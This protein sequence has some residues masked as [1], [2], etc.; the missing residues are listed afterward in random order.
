MRNYTQTESDFLIQF[1]CILKYFDKMINKMVEVKQDQFTYDEIYH[2][3]FKLN[4]SIRENFIFYK[5]GLENVYNND[6]YKQ[7]YN[8]YL[9][10]FDR[11]SE[12]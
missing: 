12:I 5:S 11:F 8:C 10:L 9:N 2:K 4:G 3:V 7:L 1:I 6:D